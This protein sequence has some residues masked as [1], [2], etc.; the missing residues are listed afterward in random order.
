MSA[1]DSY[2]LPGAATPRPITGPPE[3]DALP[4][5]SEEGASHPRVSVDVHSTPTT[6]TSFFDMRTILRA[7]NLIERSPPLPPRESTI[8]PSPSQGISFDP[9]QTLEFKR[10]FTTISR[11]HLTITNHTA[12]PHIFKVRTTHPQ[13]CVIRPRRA[14]RLDAGNTVN[15]TISQAPME[16]EPPRNAVCRVKFLIL[17]TALAPGREELSVEEAWASVP[18]G[19]SVSQH[20]LQGAWVLARAA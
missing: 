3:K 9:S 5:A 16:E 2:P 4:P 11:C 1:N 12:Q 18:E 8:Q 7:L 6:I 17:H 10:P 20:K 13:M 15:V 14:W 19:S